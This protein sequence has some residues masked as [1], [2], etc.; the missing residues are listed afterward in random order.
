MRRLALPRVF[1]HP[2]PTHRTACGSLRVSTLLNTNLWVQMT[3]PLQAR[4]EGRLAILQ[5]A[6][7]RTLPGQTTPIST[8]DPPP[9]NTPVRVGETIEGSRTMRN[10]PYQVLKCSRPVVTRQ[11]SRCTRTNEGTPERQHHR[12]RYKFPTREWTSEQRH[13]LAAN[14][15]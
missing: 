2:Q 11:L 7:T 3:I 8:T 9:M 4:E 5:R 10:R 15:K 13:D 6:S 1:H 12:W 14:V